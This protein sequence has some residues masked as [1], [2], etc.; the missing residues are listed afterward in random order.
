[1]GAEFKC[2]GAA[3]EGIR[4]NLKEATVHMGSAYRRAKKLHE[5]LGAKADWTGKSELVAE[6][7]LDILVQYQKSLYGSDTP[8][9]QAIAALNELNTNLENFY[10][11]WEQ[12]TKLEARK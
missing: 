9:M 7:F 2:D 6:G 11:N 5:T 12:Y 3:M 1:M 8:N 4:N 10:N